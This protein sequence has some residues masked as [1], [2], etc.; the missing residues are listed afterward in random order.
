[1]GKESASGHNIFQT[2]DN[3]L[4]RNT[5]HLRPQN[6]SFNYLRQSELG[7]QVAVH[8]ASVADLL[9]S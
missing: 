4:L 1:M 9:L 6:Q 5:Y 7:V 8:Y 2:E 3:V